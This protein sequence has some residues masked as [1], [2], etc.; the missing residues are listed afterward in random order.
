M[1]V[2]RKHYAELDQMLCIKQYTMEVAAACQGMGL[3]FRRVATNDHQ[4]LP[5]WLPLIHLVAATL[6]I[7]LIAP[8]KRT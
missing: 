4:N 7:D 3:T 1:A 2:V 5:L 6:R 8:R